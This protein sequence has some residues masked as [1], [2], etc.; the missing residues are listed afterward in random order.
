[1]TSDPMDNLKRAARGISIAAAEGASLVALPECFVGS[2][3]VAHFEKWAEVMGEFGG[4]AM[5][6]A[7]AKSAGIYVVGGSVSR[8][9]SRHLQAPSFSCLLPCPLLAVL[10][11]PSGRMMHIVLRSVIE[12]DREDGCMYNTSE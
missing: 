12:A 5:M 2:Y 3:G 10:S 1:V 6:S 9:R 7:A 11:S 4:S 8:P